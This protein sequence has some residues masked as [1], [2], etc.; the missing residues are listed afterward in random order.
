MLSPQQLEALQRAAASSVRCERDLN[1][2]AELTV[3]QW[4]L[5]SGWGAHQRGNNCFGIKA[6]PGCFGVQSL[7]TV[8]FIDGTRTVINQPFAIFPSLDACFAKHAALL[9]TGR[10]GAILAAYS[11]DRNL[12]LLIA[13]IS[14]VYATDPNYAKS[15]ASII[16][17][18]AVNEALSKCRNQPA[19]ILDVRPSSDHPST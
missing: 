8:E 3:A 18:S 7:P 4:A 19:P 9:K 10:Y 17:M 16:A 6:Y 11:A 13:Q 5:E 14:A 1:V 2:P 15:I 12:G